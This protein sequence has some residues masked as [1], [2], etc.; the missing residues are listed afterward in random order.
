MKNKIFFF[1]FMTI[2]IV[3]IILNFLIPPVGFS[4]Q[5]NRTLAKFPTF[6]WEKLIEGTYQEELDNYINDHFIFRNGWVK[7]KSGLEQLLGKTENNGV[8]IGKDGYLFEKFEYTQKEKQNLQIAANTINQ[9]VNK[10]EIPVSFALIP[11][12]IE[13]N[14]E[15]LPDFV[16][17]PNQKQI[18]QQMND[19]L[20]EKIN[21]V[22]LIDLLEESSKNKELQLYFKTDHHMTS[23]GSF[24]VYQKI[25]KSMGIQT[26]D[27]KEYTRIEL[28]KEFLGTFD[29]KAQIIGQEADKLDVYLNE[30]NLLL[31]EVVYDNETTKSI[32]NEAYLKKKDKYSFFL[33]GNNSKV[34]VKTKNHNGKKLLVIKDSYAHNMVPYFCQDFEE[35][36][37]IDPRYYRLPLSTYIE[38]NN[39][40]E[41]LFLY[42]VS[43]II[44]DV[45]IRNVR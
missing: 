27:L 10:I 6:T 39:L 16:K 15:K 13:I 32:F 44:Q 30:G 35:I 7:L 22:Q 43:N 18:I 11:N 45:G 21:K 4:E 36:H 14:K 25:S 5:E 34:V 42:N 2:W 37:F 29:S 20:E 19:L 8:Y 40:T 33:N 3:L 12:S 31:E 9:F 24:L 26:K 28:S 17:V 23:L 1:G 38:E 41:V